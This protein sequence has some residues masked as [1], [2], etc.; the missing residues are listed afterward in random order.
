MSS[1]NEYEMHCAQQ[2]LCEQLQR[3]MPLITDTLDLK[4]V[5]ESRY[6][7]NSPYS[8]NINKL[9]ES[10]RA[11]RMIRGDGNCFYRSF[12]IGLLEILDSEQQINFLLRIVNEAKEFLIDN[13]Y[14]EMTTDDCF[15]QWEY[16][17]VEM[18]RYIRL[19]MEQRKKLIN[20]VFLN[21]DE[22]N[23]II[24]AIRL[25]S[26]YAIQFFWEDFQYFIDCE[27]KPGESARD[28][29]RRFCQSTIEPIGRDI[30]HVTI[31]ALAKVMKCPFGIVNNG[32]GYLNR[33][34]FNLKNLDDFNE[35]V[36]IS[37]QFSGIERQIFLL[38]MMC[39]SEDDEAKMSIKYRECFQ[40]YNQDLFKDGN[41]DEKMVSDLETDVGSD[42]DSD[43]DSSLDC[44]PPEK[45]NILSRERRHKKPWT[46]KD[47]A[48]E[49]LKEIL[50]TSQPDTLQ[51]GSAFAGSSGGGGGGGGDGSDEDYDPSLD[52]KTAKRRRIL[53]K[54]KTVETNFEE[55]KKYDKRKY[56]KTKSGRHVLKFSYIKGVG[57]RDGNKKRKLDPE[58]IRILSEYPTTDLKEL[59]CN[60]D[61]GESE[62]ETYEDDPEEVELC[63]KEDYELE[64]NEDDNDVEDDLIKTVV[65]YVTE[66]PLTCVTDR[67]AVYLPK[68]TN[69]REI[70]KKCTRNPFVYIHEMKELYKNGKMKRSDIE[71]LCHSQSGGLTKFSCLKYL[72]S[73]DMVSIYNTQ[74][75]QQL[76]DNE[77]KMKR[78]KEIH[79]AYQSLDGVCKQIFKDNRQYIISNF[80]VS[81]RAMNNPNKRI[82]QSNI[83]TEEQKEMDELF[84]EIDDIIHRTNKMKNRK[85]IEN[86]PIEINTKKV[87]DDFVEKEGIFC[88][89]RKLYDDMKAMFI[90]PQMKFNKEI[91]QIQSRMK[92]KEKTRRLLFAEKEYYHPLLTVCS[93]CGR[94]ENDTVIL[95]CSS[96]YAFSKK[97][98]LNQYGCLERMGM[99]FNRLISDTDSEIS[100][101]PLFGPYFLNK[102]IRRK[103]QKQ[104][105]CGY[106][107]HFGKTEENDICMK[108]SFYKKLMDVLKSS[109]T[110]KLLRF[111]ELFIRAS[112]TKKM[113]FIY[114]EKESRQMKDK[115]KKKRS[116]NYVE[117]MRL[118]INQLQNLFNT[119]REDNIEKA[120]ST[121]E[122]EMSGMNN[123]MRKKLK[124]NRHSKKVTKLTKVKKRIEFDIERMMNSRL[125]TSK[126]RLKFFHTFM[127]SLKLTYQ[128]VR[129]LIENAERSNGAV[130][131][132]TSIVNMNVE[133]KKKACYI[134]PQGRD[135]GFEPGSPKPRT[136]RSQVAQRPD[137]YISPSSIVRNPSPSRLS[138][139][140]I[141]RRMK[142]E[143]YSDSHSKSSQK[144]ERR[145]LNMKNSSSSRALTNPVRDL[146][147]LFLRTDEKMSNRPP[148]I[149]KNV[150]VRV[151]QIDGQGSECNTSTNVVINSPRIT[152]RVMKNRLRETNELKKKEERRTG[153]VCPILQ[154]IPQDYLDM[155]NYFCRDAPIYPTIISKKEV[156]TR[157]Q[158]RQFRNS[159]VELLNLM[160]NVDIQKLIT[161]NHLTHLDAAYVHSKCALWSPYICQVSGQ[162]IGVFATIL[163]GAQNVC[164]SCGLYGATIRCKE[165]GCKV[166]LH[167]PCAL[168]QSGCDMDE[169]TY[170]IICPKHVKCDMDLPIRMERNGRTGNRN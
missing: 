38:L 44:A 164:H 86:E 107:N 68:N 47:L 70:E 136:M 146:N 83:V 126:E 142:I 105:E 3:Q 167:Y 101:G 106:F 134:T 118:N 84:G 152:R 77:W 43:N 67:G 63:R 163:F 61:G 153:F 165:R 133:P 139:S 42:D 16:I 155:Y 50:G 78:K 28:A 130:S 140:K 21:L 23:Y 60:D 4:N 30:D 94:R 160:K 37:P 92:A 57:N 114:M 7:D 111:Y 148:K 98:L 51:G 161:F 76:E 15:S 115:F 108:S 49:V 90:K 75:F 79:D 123:H 109:D 29:L 156:F 95:K 71:L 74:L 122:D 135:F 66:A 27:T 2:K 145:H 22:S 112:M 20:N 113:P 18:K 59:L 169:S 91:F 116:L 41:V 52:K 99:F 35:N 87:V 88:Q 65:P 129:Q 141:S 170:R 132:S 168:T 89:D 143:N 64:I 73:S 26:S 117:E 34:N 40:L 82:Q 11:I 36:I 62:D 13:G 96:K 85:E 54:I 137:H 125:D 33:L 154:R 14:D 45:P 32:D 110:S 31:T 24:A 166:V 17:L 102:E 121:D 147:K 104:Y 48:P 162:I 12:A 144:L 127:E 5:L 81:T 158:L 6:A 128:G 119:L 131:S 1:M 9:L 97:T 72:V 8:K 151:L 25:I 19:P 120:Y 69:D 56:M 80:P 46:I 100:L 10:F 55:K 150:T 138:P 93:L 39:D 103:L 157:T 124:K 149:G 53:P 58:E 159:I